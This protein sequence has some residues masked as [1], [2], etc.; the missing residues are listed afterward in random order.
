[1]TAAIGRLNLIHALAAPAA[2]YRALV[3]VFLW[4]QRQRNMIIPNDTAGYA[5]QHSLESRPAAEHLAALSGRAVPTAC[6]HQLGFARIVRRKRLALVAKSG[7]LAQPTTAR[8]S[9]SRRRYLGKSTR[10]PINRASG[11]QRISPASGT[12]GWAGRCRMTSVHECRRSVS[13]Y[14]FCG[15]RRDSVH[16][17][18]N[19]SLRFKR[20]RRRVARLWHFSRVE[21]QLV[22]FQQLLTMDSGI[23]LVQDTSAVMDQSLEQSKILA[24]S[25]SLSP[26][27]AIPTTNIGIN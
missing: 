2:R 5:L 13:A 10:I 16:R 20:V 8:A 1:M 11:K 23:S 18:A 15:R 21:C 7:T 24:S 27:K 19:T 17:R 6:I 9:T 4:R 14:H 25:L 26:L 3:C 22:S 12:T